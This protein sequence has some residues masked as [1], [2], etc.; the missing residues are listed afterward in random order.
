MLL[1]VEI[2]TESLSAD[3]TGKWLLIV[4]RVHVK[5]QVVNLVESLITD[6]TFE[7]FLSAV[8]QPVIFVIAL[9]MKALAAVLADE[10]LVVCVDARVGV[11]R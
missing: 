6:F 1:E 3:R 7:R 11:Q 4:V 10:R 9:L 8:R 2:P 5:R